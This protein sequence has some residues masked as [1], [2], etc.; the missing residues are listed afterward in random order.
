MNRGRWGGILTSVVVSR[1][2]GSSYFTANRRL[3][4]LERDLEEDLKE[5]TLEDI[6][7]LIYEFRKEKLDQ[8]ED[9]VLARYF[10]SPVIRM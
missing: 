7:Q 1:L 4:Q 8:A 10:S 9:A 5:V 3:K 2:M 6:G